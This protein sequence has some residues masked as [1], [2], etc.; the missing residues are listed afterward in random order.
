[1]KNVLPGGPEWRTRLNARQSGW[2]LWLTTIHFALFISH[3]FSTQ[4]QP[5][6]RAQLVGTWIGVRV[7]YDDQFHRPNPVCIMLGADSTYSFGLIDANSPVRQSTW[8]ATNQSVRLD[9][10]TYTLSQWTL[11]GNELRLSGAFPMTFRR[12]NEFAI[13]SVA[14]HQ[15][16][17][18]YSWSTD[19]ISYQ[20]QADGS[21]CLKNL[22]TGDVA[23]HCWKLAQIGRSVFIVIKGNRD[24]CDGN[25]QYPLQITQLSADTMQCRGG[26]TGPDDRVLFRRGARLANESHCEPKGFQPC[27]TYIFPPFNLYPYF[28]YRRGRL[29][30]IRQ[31]IDR[32]YKP[33]VL[34]GQSGLIRF[35]FVVNCRGEAGRFEVLEVDENYEKCSFDLRI[36]DQLNDICRTKLPAWE[37]GKPNGETEPIDTVCLLTFRLKDGLITEIFP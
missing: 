16:L 14:V 7:E 23:V 13:D 25:F 12:L 9:T 21:V 27:R 11:S 10:S 6:T 18:G 36:I 2:Q 3:C 19:S 20:F 15:T 30:D 34:P 28:F 26:G 1:M 31:V 37:P 33:V 5:P 22:K 29:F 4:A 35:R 32:A 24:G 8:S 17:S